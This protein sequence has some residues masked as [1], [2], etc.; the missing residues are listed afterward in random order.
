MTDPS[1]ETVY[2]EKLYEYGEKLNNAKD[3]S[4]VSLFVFY[5]GFLLLLFVFCFQLGF[6][7]LDLLISLF[8]YFTER[9]GL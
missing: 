1:E 7:I 4:Q 5:L 6:W 9:E 3:K 8:V 2:I